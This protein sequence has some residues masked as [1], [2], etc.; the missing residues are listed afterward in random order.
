[1]PISN[2]GN[3]QSRNWD[4]ST[5]DRADTVKQPERRHFLKTA[6][7][8]GAAVLAGAGQAFPAA[9]PNKV[10]VGGHAWVYAAPMPAHD[11]TPV[12][13]QIFS[14]FKYAGIDAFELMDVVLTHDD[15]V[16]RIGALSH[17]YSLPILG[18]SFSGNMWDRTKHSA[19]LAAAETTITRLAQLGGRT[20][21][22]SVG[23]ARAPKTPE[24]L[25]AQAE[26]LRK[27]IAMCQ[28]HG[29]V[30]NLH[31]HTY[32]VENGMHDLEGTLARI[33][34]VKLGPDLNWLV[35]GGVNPVDFIHRFGKQIVY[36]HI[37]DQKTDGTWS[38]AVGEGNMDYPAIAKALHAVPFSGDATIELAHEKGFQLT[39]PLREDW[40]ISREFVR[41]TLGY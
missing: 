10:L 31:N 37:R 40:K 8:M 7:A 20:F 16:D 34:D 5:E 25:D 41:K 36:L 12:I 29:V 23:A 13:E 28:A 9:R 2:T 4:G 17:K 11:Y 14:D 26:I 35:R 30:L 33:P 18:T 27:I 21:G 19:I 32:E 38:E 24:Q 3:K 6:A 22:T 39:R 1:M 15:A